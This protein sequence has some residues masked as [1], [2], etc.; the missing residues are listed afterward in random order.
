[1]LTGRKMETLFL[2]LLQA[3]EYFVS[4]LEIKIQGLAAVAEYTNTL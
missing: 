2:L 4:L 3:K 1:M